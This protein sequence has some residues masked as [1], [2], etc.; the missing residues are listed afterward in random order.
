MVLDGVHEIHVT[1]IRGHCPSPNPNRGEAGFKV[2][3]YHLRNA[4]TRLFHHPGI[5]LKQ[6]EILYQL[7]PQLT[8]LAGNGINGFPF[9]N[10][11]FFLFPSQFFIFL[12]SILI[13]NNLQVPKFQTSSDEIVCKKVSLISE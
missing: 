9:R 3:V 7:A 2:D 13:N 6:M 11:D 12:H 4:T 1:Y 8:L 10:P 5:H